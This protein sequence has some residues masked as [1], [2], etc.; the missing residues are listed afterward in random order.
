[1]PGHGSSNDEREAVKVLK[2][3]AIARINI[4]GRKSRINAAGAKQ[5]AKG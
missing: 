2:K 1:M 4:K 5:E 3:T